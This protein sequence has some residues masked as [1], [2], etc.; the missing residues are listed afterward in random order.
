MDQGSSTFMAAV[1]LAKVLL[2]TAL[3]LNNSVMLHNITLFLVAMCWCWNLSI[4][5]LIC[6]RR[7]TVESYWDRTYSIV[8][9]SFMYHDHEMQENSN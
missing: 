5:V 6:S 7:I 1:N 2:T 8:E 4:A 3:L 9:Y